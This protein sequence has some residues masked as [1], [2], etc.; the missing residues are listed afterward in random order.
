MRNTK[1]RREKKFTVNIRNAE[2][3]V[4]SLWTLDF[5]P[6]ATKRLTEGGTYSVDD[7]T[8]SDDSKSMGS[9]GSP[10]TATSVASPPRTSTAISTWRKLPPAPLSG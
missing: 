9:A 7:V 1:V 10:R 2:T 3:P 5:E 6:M 4:S 8:I